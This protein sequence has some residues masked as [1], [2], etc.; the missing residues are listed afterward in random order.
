MKLRAVVA[1]LGAFGGPGAL[2]EHGLQPRR[3]AAQAGRFP[4]AG[5]LVLSGTQPGP[6]DQVSGGRKA[7]HV[8]AD[9]GE[10]GGRRKATDAGDR[11][12]AIDQL[13]KGG[14]SPFG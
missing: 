7:A 6:G 1:V 9:L 10:D 13:A 11:R 14:L 12:Q 2:Y 8:A 5:T 3:P 4:L